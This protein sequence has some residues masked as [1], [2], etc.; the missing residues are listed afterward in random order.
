MAVFWTSVNSVPD[1]NHVSIP[2]RSSL[3]IPEPPP[4]GAISDRE[5]IA[6]MKSAIALLIAVGIAPL[7]IFLATYHLVPELLSIDIAPAL[8]HHAEIES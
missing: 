1:K 3:A 8:T 5:E 2:R 6:D 7:L 4:D